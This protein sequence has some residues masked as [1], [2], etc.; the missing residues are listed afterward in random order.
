MLLVLINR[1]HGFASA[2]L[3][4]VMMRHLTPEIHYQESDLSSHLPLSS[5]SF[6]RTVILSFRLVSI[7]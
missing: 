6:L 2:G 3:L 5:I 7:Y 4:N 1:Q